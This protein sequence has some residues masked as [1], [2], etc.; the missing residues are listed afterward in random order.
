M[1][2]K[3]NLADD[4]YIVTT[5]DPMAIYAANN[6]CKGIEKFAQRGQVHLGGLIYNGRSAIN[7]P[8]IVD[9]FAERI[10]TRVVGRL[11][12]SNLISRA[13]MRHKTVIEYARDSSIA[14]EFMTLAREIYDSN[15]RVVP[16]PLSDRD[17]DDIIHEL[18]RLFQEREAEV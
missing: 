16:R 3:N 2:L 11:P 18:D 14:Q 6:I 1:P 7:A 4:V 17:L 9:K 15:V 12:M 5:C 13:E 10:G 8:H